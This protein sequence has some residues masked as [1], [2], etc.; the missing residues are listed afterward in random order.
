MNSNPPVTAPNA[1]RRGI[2]ND[3]DMRAFMESS[4]KRE[5]LSFV[6]ALGKSCTVVDPKGARWDPR[7]PLQD[8]PPS[9]ACLHGAL[10]QMETWVDEFPPTN[11]EAARFGNPAFRLW[12]TRLTQRSH[13]IVTAILH[14][15]NSTDSVEQASQNGWDAAA[16]KTSPPE[17]AS[18]QQVSCYLHDSFGHATRLDF[19]TGHESSFMV[20]LYVLSKVKCL[21]AQTPPP[22]AAMKLVTLSLFD[23]YLKV[24]RRLQT[25]YRL[26]PAGSHG[27]WGLDDYHCLPFYFGACQLQALTKDN[28]AADTLSRPSV[29]NDMDMLKDYGDQYLYLSCIRYIR[30]LKQ[31]VPFFES[32]PMLYDISQ[33]MTT[34]DKVARG[35]LRLYQGEVLDKRQV[36]QHFLFSKLFPL[37]WAP[38]QAIERQAPTT[39]FRDP[40]MPVTRAPW[41]STG[42][43]GAASDDAIAPTRAPWASEAAPDSSGDPMAPTRAPWAT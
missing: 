5:L 25:D 9:M 41:S 24:T 30:K 34:W 42:P 2:Y 13:A 18:V 11:Q 28:I 8:L 15:R 43:P 26:E 33:T 22:L 19:G 10:R 12:H 31:G 6:E 17:D 40:P 37:T 4:T 36:V 1:P 35:M 21:G 23:Q 7:H 27:V 29:V 16:G 14:A 38:S 3:V 20:F 32:S 39:T